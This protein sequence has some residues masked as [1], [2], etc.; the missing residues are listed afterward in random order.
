M[1]EEFKIVL[2]GTVVDDDWSTL[3]T[4]AHGNAMCCVKAL[5]HCLADISVKILKEDADA[6]AA[7]DSLAELVRDAFLEKAKEAGRK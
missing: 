6:E 2:Q 5:I 1:S 7:A 4:K 3:T